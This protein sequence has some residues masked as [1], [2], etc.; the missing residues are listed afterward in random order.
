MDTIIAKI[1]SLKPKYWIHIENGIFHTRMNYVK[2]IENAQVK[3]N[4]NRA[5]TIKDYTIKNYMNLTEE[6]IESSE[7]SSK[8]SFAFSVNHVGTASFDDFVNLWNKPTK[9]VNKICYEYI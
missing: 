1:Q 8:P 2:T 3:W 6:Y 5:K 9:Y 4:R 7:M